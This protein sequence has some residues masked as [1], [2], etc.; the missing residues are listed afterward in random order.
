MANKYELPE[1]KEKNIFH[2]TEAERTA[3]G[4]YSL[5]GS[6]NE[7][8]QNTEKSQ[9]VKEALGDHVFNAFIENKKAEWDAYRINVTKWELDR[10]LPIL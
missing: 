10:Y 5:P 1:P 7:A 4:I 9:L 6:L 8:L 3:E 2:M